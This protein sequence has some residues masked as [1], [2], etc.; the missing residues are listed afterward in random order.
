MKLPEVQTFKPGAA[1]LL[2]DS[3]EEERLGRCIRGHK[4]T[5]H[6]RTHTP[7]GF[8]QISDLPDVE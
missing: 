7:M 1:G 8:N 6:T 2:L 5:T 3:R 4:A